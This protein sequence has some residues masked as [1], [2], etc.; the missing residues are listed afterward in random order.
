[1]KDGRLIVDA[2][3]ERGRRVLVARVLAA[4]LAVALVA[5]GSV[6][7]ATSGSPV[8]VYRTATAQ[9]A[10]VEQGLHLTGVLKSVS[11]VNA[12][13][14]VTGTVATVP[15]RLGQQVRAGQVLATLQP[16]SLQLALTQ[17]QAGLAAAAAT[18]AGDQS[19]AVARASPPPS[20]GASGHG[21]SA[22]LA[23]ASRL[24]Q[25]LAAS[26]RSI[27]T[28]LASAAAALHQLQAACGPLN[29]K[30]APA[31]PSA[32]PVAAPSAKPASGAPSSGECLA[33]ARAT[34]A[35][36]QKVASAETTVLHEVG[37]ALSALQRSAAAPASAPASSTTGSGG[38]GAGAAGGQASPSKLAADTANVATA[39]AAVST[40]TSDLAAAALR[41]PVTGTIADLPFAVGSVTSRSESA[42]IVGSNAEQVSVQ[43]P[44]ADMPLVKSGQG[45]TVTPD[46]ALSP[47]SAVVSAI[48]LLPV[49]GVAATAYPVTL[50]VSGVRARLGSGLP[51]SVDLIVG[52]AHNVLTVP[53]SAVTV[54]GST[55]VVSVLTPA[56]TVVVTHVQVGV[57]GDLLTEITGGL[58]L[59][60]TVVLA[61]LNRPLPSNSM[62]NLRLFAKPGGLRFAARPGGGRAHP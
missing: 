45:G 11:Q 58:A 20:A 29:A 53:N 33:A 5:G 55:G 59:G 26:Q 46:G 50:T 30:P 1:M 57:V 52:S 47:M 17:A 25:A 19:S 35:A 23:A 60:Q 18:L 61:D 31:A 4:V 37:Q 44:L 9:R 40:A 6:A 36:Q 42:V 38:G 32:K 14:A 27:A 7:Y 13:F 22:A 54:S 62:T 21:D 2:K 15:V 24:R 28:G 41:S 51:A 16:S 34:Q 12:T 3:N 48:G 49:P 39:Q 56:H 8:A 10:T 43:V